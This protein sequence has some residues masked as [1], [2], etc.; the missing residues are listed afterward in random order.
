MAADGPPGDNPTLPAQLLEAILLDS[1]TA[2]LL[3]LAWSGRT[4][5]LSRH[6]RR[7]HD[8]RCQRLCLRDGLDDD[9]FHRMVS[10]VPRLLRL[11]VSRCS[12]LSYPGLVAVTTLTHLREL[13]LHE[14]P[15]NARLL[16][17]LGGSLTVL[18]LNGMGLTQADVGA[19]RVPHILDY[20]LVQ[21]VDYI[22][23][24]T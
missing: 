13:A 16:P 11:D 2:Q 15:R 9:T 3:G 8:S 17:L 10:L 12:L 4:R 18:H 21:V 7:A 20:T 14:K 24:T 22:D 23:L 6:W 5:L 19:I 1:R